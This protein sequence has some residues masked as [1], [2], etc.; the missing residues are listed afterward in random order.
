MK[1]KQGFVVREV[2]GS[3]VAVPIGEMGEKFRGM[4]NLNGTGAFL[5]EFFLKE[6]TLDEAVSALC[7]AY[8]VMEEEARAD[9][10]T[11]MQTLIKNGFAE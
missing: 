7:A 4:I 9:V 8:E 3:F 10:Q 2:G 11:F 1:I 5:W 6:R